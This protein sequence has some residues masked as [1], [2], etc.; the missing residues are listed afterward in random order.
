VASINR[1]LA[2]VKRISEVKSIEGADKIVAYRIDGWWVVDSKDKYRV[3]DLAVYC[4]IDSWIPTE[5]APFLSKGKDPSEYNGVKGERLRSVRLKGQI[6]QGLLIEMERKMDGGY[7]IPVTRRCHAQEGE[8]VTEELGIQKWEAPVPAQLAGEV[9]GV[10]PTHLVPKT[11]QERIQNCIADIKDYISSNVDFD[12]I[13]IETA[14]AGVKAPTKFIVEEKLDGS[15]CTIILHDGKMQ[16][17]S[18]NL[19]MRRNENNS[20]WK[21]ASKYEETL[22]AF[23]T[24]TGRSFALQGELI[25]EGIQGNPYKLTGQELYVF[26]MY[27]ID[28]QFY[29][30]RDVREKFVDDFGMKNVP[31]LSS[32]DCSFEEPSQ[33]TVELCLELAEG[34]SALNPDVEREGVVFKCANRG[35]LSFKAISN[36]WLI[37]TG[38]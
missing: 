34:K 8:D 38:K 5:L 14:S 33:I 20:F 22:L 30:V 35:S 12:E 3:G 2:T 18:R 25:G 26:D 36:R 10:F 27:D 15:S 32:L 16:V 29:L 6:S 13:D 7:L 1:K 9:D 4:E 37:K 28:N 19:I 24:S 23:H 21:V 11:D 17:C 31:H